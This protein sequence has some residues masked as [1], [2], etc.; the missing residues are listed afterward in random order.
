MNIFAKFNGNLS[1]T[2]KTYD[3]I[4]KCQLGGS[5]KGKAKT[6]LSS[7]GFILWGPVLQYIGVKHHHNQSNSCSYISTWT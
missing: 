5:V 2:V 6:L 4:Q 3:L 1:N 7:R